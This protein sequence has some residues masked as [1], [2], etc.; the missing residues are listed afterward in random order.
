M[1]LVK[2]QGAVVLA[3]LLLL[4]SFAVAEAIA[5]DSKVTTEFTLKLQDGTVVATTEGKEP[6]TFQMGS[7]AMMPAVQSQIVGMEEGQTKTLTLGPEQAFGQSN[8]EAI[9]EIDTEKIPVELRK[10]GQALSLSGQDGKPIQA[11]VVEIGEEKSK[12]DFN[13]PLAGRTVVVELK[14]IKVE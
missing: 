14:I 9:K 1:R 12:L 4:S 5:E 8:P 7:K 3:L 13:H 2:T 10:V 11:R 6:V